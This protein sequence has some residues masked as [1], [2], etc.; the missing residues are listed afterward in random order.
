MSRIGCRRMVVDDL[1]RVLA[2]EQDSFPTPWTRRH[3]LHELQAN[4]FGWN[5]VLCDGDEIIGYASMWAAGYELH[6]ND[7]AVDRSRRREGL[8]RFLMETVLRE[9][10]KRGC[11][12]VV[13]EVRYRNTAARKL[14]EK[15]GFR[16]TGRRRRYY[17][18]T[19]DDALMLE[20]DL[21][22]K[23]SLLSGLYRPIV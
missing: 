15:L 2:I 13:L 4:P 1:D 23:K 12:K 7:V 19:G 11:A 3:F 9:G 18:D 14:Y 8:G 17:Q 6:I 5:L 20:R 10:V 21:G 22:R 16:I